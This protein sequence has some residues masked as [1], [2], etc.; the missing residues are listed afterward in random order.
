MRSQTLTVVFGSPEHGWL[1]VSVETPRGNLHRDVSD[2]P[3]DTL[4][5]LVWVLVRLAKGSSEERVEWSLE[6]KIWCWTFTVNEN[7]LRL[8][9]EDAFDETLEVCLPLRNALQLLCRSLVRLEANTAWARADATTAVWRWQF[10]HRDLARLRRLV[11][12]S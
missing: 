7:G 10:P 8:G 3:A 5:E 12:D 1:P 2:V 9:V 6:P 11:L 4:T